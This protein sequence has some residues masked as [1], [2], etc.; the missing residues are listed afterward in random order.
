[1]GR[2]RREENLLLFEWK[3]SHRFQGIGLAECDQRFSETFVSQRRLFLR[4]P[5][6]RIPVLPF[7]SMVVV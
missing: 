3:P 6:T 5:A 2:L 7:K 1:M 4:D